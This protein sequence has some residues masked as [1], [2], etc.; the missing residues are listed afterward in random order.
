LPGREAATFQKNGYDAHLSFWN[1]YVGPNKGPLW[2]SYAVADPYSSCTFLDDLPKRFGFLG[3]CALMNAQ[4]PP[5][6]SYIEARI[7]TWNKFYRDRLRWVIHNNRSRPHFFASH[8]P[9]PGHAYSV[10]GVV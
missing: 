7:E 5:I 3:Y 2:T 9:R 8:Y 6:A 10:I 4:S 1:T